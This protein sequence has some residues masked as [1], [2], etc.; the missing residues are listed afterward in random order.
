MDK[1]NIDIRWEQRFDNLEKAFIKYE[2]AIKDFENLSDLS[3]EGLVQRF[4]YTLELFWLTMK[5]FLENQG[6]IAKFPRE[7]I[8]KSFQFEIIDD[9]E[10]WMDMLEK[11][12]LLSHTFDEENFNMAL[13]LIV[14][15]YYDSMLKA[16]TYFQMRYY[17]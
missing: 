11:R 8:K 1:E 3:K 10:I 15:K 16:Y 7:V 2:S 14:N 9:G 12:N 13:E 17:A 5:D 4:E 6:V